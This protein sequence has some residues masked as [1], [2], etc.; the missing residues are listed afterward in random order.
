M[1][2]L[3]LTEIQLDRLVSYLF[4]DD[5]NEESEKDKKLR[6]HKNDVYKRLK[7]EFNNSL[8]GLEMCDDVII[9][10]AKEDEDEKVIEGSKS[11][12]VL[13]I[14]GIN[15]KGLKFKVIKKFGADTGLILNQV[16]T[17]LYSNLFNIGNDGAYLKFYTIDG[18]SKGREIEVDGFEIYKVVKNSGNC[19]ANTEDPELI[20]KELGEQWKQSVDDL[21]QKTEYE[22]GLFGMNNIFFFPKG[23][24]A[25]D[26]ILKKYGLGVKKEYKDEKV[27]FR[28]LSN[29]KRQCSLKKGGVVEGI[30]NHKNDIEV[31]G[32]YLEVPEG[33]E[34][35]QG[36]KFLVDVFKV[37]SKTKT[38]ITDKLKIEILEPK[39]EGVE[40]D[41]FV[42]DDEMREKVY[43]S[44]KKISERL[45]EMENSKEKI[46][47]NLF[48]ALYNDYE[49]LTNLIKKHE[50]N[51]LESKLLDLDNKFRQIKSKVQD[52]S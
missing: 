32:L 17:F 48:N 38:P 16:Y 23:F 51:E 5:N 27:V 30:I 31:G 8:K 39:K 43:S 15:K 50:Y 6:E 41:I 36:E 21:F 52:N 37:T 10:F 14:T 4:E 34:I 7:Q 47:I 18:G 29:P 42:D 44:F 11:L 28:V 22:P 12:L 26:D 13:R 35:I 24:S 40:D 19:K 45:K 49:K 1:K 46:D 25:M 2:K 20:S 3:I 33:E 9:Q